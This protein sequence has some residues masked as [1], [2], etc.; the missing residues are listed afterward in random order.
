M[1]MRDLVPWRRGEITEGR[2]L[3]PFR[4]LQ[5]DFD[6]LMDDFTRAFRGGE[7]EPTWGAEFFPSVNV[8]EKDKEIIVTAE[9]PGLDEKE[10]DVSLSGHTLYIR[11]E[12]KEEKEEKGE[13][14]YRTERHFGSFQR[15]IPL[16]S[17]VQED[18]ITASYKKGV[19]KI[20]LPKSEQSQKTRKKIDIQS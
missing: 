10:I 12:K 15:A 20:A 17:E 3:H 8:A 4:A 13:Q 11:G 5:R 7:L 14:F 19:L 18:K 16:P 6:R 2:E 9:I 1:A